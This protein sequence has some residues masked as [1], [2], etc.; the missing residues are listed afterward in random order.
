MIISIITLFPDLYSAFLKTSLVRRA[1]EQGYITVTLHNLFDFCK[2]KERVDS[3]PFGHGA[4]LLLRPDIVEKGVDAQE[5]T[6]GSAYKIFFS[7]QGQKLNQDIL[8]TIAQESSK[9]GHIMLLPA[10]YEGMDARVEEYYADCIISL[11]DFVIM[12]GDLPAM[13]LMEGLFRLFPGVVGKQESV[14]YESFSGPF[15]DYRHYTQPVVW[16]GRTVPDVVRSGNHAQIEKFNREDAVQRTVLHH[17]DW[18][19][20]H[21]RS[22]DDK[23]L[24]ERCIPAHYAVL[25][26]TNVL[27][28]GG[29]E[30]TSS[31]TSLDI[32]DIA[33]SAR[34]FGIKKYFIVT[35]LVD[36]QKVIRKLLDFWK[37]DVGITYNPSRHE[38]L[39]NV[40]LASTIDEVITHI[41]HLENAQPLLIATAA[42]KHQHAQSITYYDQER[43]WS[44]RRPILFVFGTARGLAFSLISRCEFILEP[45]EGFS[46]FNHL[47]VRSAAAIIFDRWLGINSV[48]EYYE[49]KKVY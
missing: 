19:R 33:R 26:H 23:A 6:Y 1:Q 43:V 5:A 32:H 46:E 17:F 44:L 47:S 48:K 42:R 9:K 37:T 24:A 15:L 4:G 10:R 45:I 18:L 35:P 21:I 8:Q 31:V 34:T 30:G 29:R 41:E 28:E 13:V 38:A 40:I 2:P 22:A 39:N 14:K 27:L 3:P 12:G 7:P 16:K 25:M 20:S 49:S 36:Q 11:G